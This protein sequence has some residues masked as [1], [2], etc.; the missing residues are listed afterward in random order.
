MKKSPLLITAVITVLAL[1]LGG[2]SIV[3]DRQQPVSSDGTITLRMAQTSGL[4][5]RTMEN[6]IHIAFWKEMGADATPM[7]WSDAYPALQQGALD[8]QENPSTVILTNNVAQVNNQLAVTEH[9]YSTVFLIMSPTT[10]ANLGEE[11]QA[12]FKEVMAEC[13]VSERELSR[14]MDAE[15]IGKLEEQG[16]TATYPDKQEFIDKAANL[17]SQWEQTYGETISKIRALGSN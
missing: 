1:A 10:W 3:K 6:Q 15:A 5:I 12:I 4:T 17:Y 2:F 13:S 8:G 16:M 9:A 14:Q 11:Y 7:S